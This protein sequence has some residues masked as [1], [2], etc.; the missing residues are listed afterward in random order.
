MINKIKKILK[1]NPKIMHTEEEAS[2]LI[3]SH[4]VKIRMKL[5]DPEETLQIIME[6][7][8]QE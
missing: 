6:R 7:G 5:E 4:S 8:T 2:E 1:Q 3:S